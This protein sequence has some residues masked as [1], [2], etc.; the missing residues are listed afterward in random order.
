MANRIYNFNPG[1]ATLPFPTLEQAQKE[2]LDYH[3]SGMSVTEISH[4]SKEFDAIL[5]DAKSLLHETMEIPENYKVL[6]LQGG[7][8]LQFAMVPMNLLP[9]GQ[10]ADYIVTGSWA[11]KALKEAQILGNVNIAASTESDG[12]LRMPKLGELNLDPKASYLHITSNETISGTQ[13][14]EFPDS[15]QVPMV[16]DMSSDILS[17]RIDVKRFGLMYAGAQKN[18]GPAGVTIVIIRD[19][20]VEK[21]SESLP[22]LLSYKTHVSKNSLYNTPPVFSIYMVKLVLDWVKAEGGM[23]KIEEKNK[24]KARL[25]Y[26]ILDQYPD[27][28]K[29]AA[30]N[31]SRSIMNVT[32]RMT[33]EDLE[34]KFIAEASSAGFHGL[35]GHRSVGGIRISMYNAMPLE[36]IEKLVAFMEE[37]RKKNV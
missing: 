19:D 20:L 7:A 32:L 22:T 4:R 23:K 17:R 2:F 36:G 3:A 18:L 35:K 13:W 25:V 31:E 27:Y 10:S 21:C 6:F 5:E 29:S 34:K 9:P 16:A 1:P 30:E 11:K 15:G 12:F 33:S 24:E 37:F 26:G 14:P 28:Y 8:S